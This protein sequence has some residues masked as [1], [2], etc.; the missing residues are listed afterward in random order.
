M[1]TLDWIE[2]LVQR[3][4]VKDAIASNHSI[5]N[6]LLEPCFDRFVEFSEWQGRTVSWWKQPINLVATAPTRARALAILER[7][8]DEDAWLLALDAIRA[9][10]RALHRVVPSEASRVGDAVKSGRTGDPNASGRW[11]CLI[12][13]SS[14]IL[15]LWC[16]SLSGSYC[17]AI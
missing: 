14:A 17:C 13:S 11:R 16:G 6:T 4:S 9:I 8:I 12:G 1:S 2:R 5:L 10:E 7:V 15:K 3:P